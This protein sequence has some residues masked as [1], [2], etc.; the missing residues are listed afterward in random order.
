VWIANS[1]C[2]SPDRPEAIALRV[3][4][5][6]G[7][8]WPDDYQRNLARA[9]EAPVAAPQGDAEPRHRVSHYA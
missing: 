1:P 6:G 5:I 2:D 7:K 3:T 9:V 8:H 4:V